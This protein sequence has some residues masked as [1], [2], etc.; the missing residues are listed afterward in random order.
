MMGMTRTGGADRADRAAVSSRAGGGAG[1]IEVPAAVQSGM[2]LLRRMQKI[3]P[4]SLAA[5]VELSRFL[6][7]IGM[8]EEACR[9]L[10]R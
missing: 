9:N 5:H 7:S 4:G 3:M 2:D 6:V 10:R 8:H 1:H